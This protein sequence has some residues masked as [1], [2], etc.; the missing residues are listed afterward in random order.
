MS[1]PQDIAAT[2]TTAPATVCSP[3]PRISPDLH[4]WLNHMLGKQEP[5]YYRQ[6]QGVCREAWAHDKSEGLHIITIHA[7]TESTE[8]TDFKKNNQAFVKK[9]L[10]AH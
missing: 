3:P 9:K 2:T 8:G 7:K 5:G 6:G 4:G 1:Q 10:G